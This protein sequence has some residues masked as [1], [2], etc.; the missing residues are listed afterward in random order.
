VE[1][2]CAPHGNA[3]PSPHV[4]ARYDEKF[5]EDMGLGY[6]AKYLLDIARAADGGDFDMEHLKRL[7]SGEAVAYATR[8]R[9]IGEKVANCI[10]LYGLHR[11]DAFPVD[12]WVAQAIESQYGGRFPIEKFSPYAGIVQ[13]YVFFYQRSRRGMGAVN[14]NAARSVEGSWVGNAPRKLKISLPGSL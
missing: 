2:L 8:F 14:P 7:D 12:T 13:Q 6:R 1:K 10:A 5:F 9:G 3:F 11:L 4:L